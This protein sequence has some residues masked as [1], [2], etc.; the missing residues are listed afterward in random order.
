MAIPKTIHYCWFGRGEKPKEI[1]RCIKSW[2][3]YCPDYEIIEWNEDNYPLSQ[4]PLYVR[5]AYEAKKWAFVT[6]YVRLELLYR[7]GGLYFDTD[8]ELI[9]S[10]AALLENRCFMGIE[11][12]TRCVQVASGLGSGA[13]AGF[14]LLKEMM[15]DY[16]SIP[17]FQPDGSID[18]TTCTARNTAVLKRYGYVEEDRLQHVAGA[19]IYPSEYFSPIEMESGKK[20]VT[21]NTVS[22]HHYSLSWTTP[23]R[24]AARKKWLRKRKWLDL[25]YQIK[26]LPNR[27]AKAILGEKRY[28]RLKG[29]F[30]K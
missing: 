29:R 5:Q 11:K 17:F 27:L 19:V 6:D 10:P 2:K 7:L 18:I 24:R 26:V 20:R 12:S 14:P 9:K 30:R 22:I 21:P 16:Q 15:E 8:V 1:Q 4:A 28:E 25:R 23:E 3:K 13:E